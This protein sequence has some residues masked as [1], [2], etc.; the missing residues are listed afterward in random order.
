MMRKAIRRSGENKTRP[1]VAAAMSASRLAARS[2]GNACRISLATALE[3]VVPIDSS[4]CNATTR[5]LCY[6]PQRP[7]ILPPLAEVMGVRQIRQSLPSI[8]AVW[9]TA[10]VD[11]LRT[12]GSALKPDHRTP[13]PAARTLHKPTCTSVGPRVEHSSSYGGD[14]GDNLSQVVAAVAFLEFRA[15]RRLSGSVGPPIPIT[16]P[17][18]EG[19]LDFGTTLAL[20]SL[21]GFGGSESSG[22]IPAPS[23]ECPLGFGTTS[24]PCSFNSFRNR[25][26]SECDSAC[27]SRRN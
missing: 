1:A 2:R 24:T 6:N 7:A 19:L 13:M 16:W 12:F 25:R 17:S 14:P 27:T 3:L 20:C 23:T 21:S 22:P 5:A 10:S 15:A 18:T 4:S 8:A 9:V 26:C 11:G